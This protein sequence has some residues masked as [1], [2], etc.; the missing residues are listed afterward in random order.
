MCVLRYSGISGNEIARHQE[1]EGF[2][3]EFT[4]PE[5][6]LGVVEYVVQLISGP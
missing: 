3:I 6:G 1:K 5:P 4:R 2:Q